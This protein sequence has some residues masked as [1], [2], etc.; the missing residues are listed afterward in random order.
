MESDGAQWEPEH[1]LIPLGYRNLLSPPHAKRKWEEKEY[2]QASLPALWCLVCE[3]C[4]GK[5]T[6]LE[7]PLT[8]S[9][10][11]DVT[12]LSEVSL[13]GQCLINV[14]MSCWTYQENMVA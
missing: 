6:S 13:Y 11:S 9:T 8:G 5:E 12:F 7:P 4:P 1:T 2:K 3:Y 14:S 10:V